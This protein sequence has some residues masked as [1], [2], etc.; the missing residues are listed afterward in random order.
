MCWHT[1][2]SSNGWALV[3]FWTELES[4]HVPEIRNIISITNCWR[5]LT[6]IRWRFLLYIACACF[7]CSQ[8]LPGWKGIET[9]G[10]EREDTEGISRGVTRLGNNQITRCITW[11]LNRIRSIKNGT[12]YHCVVS[13][14]YYT[15]TVELRHK[16]LG[17]NR[18]WKENHFC[19]KFVFHSFKQTSL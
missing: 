14:N 16:Y 6:N 2:R 8:D 4:M 9:K 12:K 3:V 1:N 15:W 5:D 18:I 10:N 11:H 17:G 7:A 13:I 19:K